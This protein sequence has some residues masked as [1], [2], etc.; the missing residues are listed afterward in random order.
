MILLFFQA[1]DGI[2]DGHVTGVQTCALP[3]FHAVQDVGD[4]IGSVLV[5]EVDILQAQRAA[6]GGEVDLGGFLGGDDRVLRVHHLV[7]TVQGGGGVHGLPEQ[8]AEHAHRAHHEGGGGEVGGQLP[9]VHRAVR[10]QVQTQEKGDAERDL[11]EH[12][13][14]RKSVV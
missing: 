8:H 3:I 14:D 2:R 10:G 9:R 4:V 7:V 5:A 6:R 13:Q 11:G 1:E 12:E